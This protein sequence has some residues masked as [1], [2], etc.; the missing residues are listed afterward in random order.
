MLDT[1]NTVV[2]IKKRGLNAAWSIFRAALLIGLGFVILYPLLYMLSMS[3][4]PTVDLY[5]PNVV[6]LPNSLTMVNIT[7]VFEVMEYPK[8][9]GLTIAFN[10]GSSLLSVAVCMIT[11]YGFARFKF[12]GASLLFAFLLMTIIVPIQITGTPLFM[13][14]KALGILDNPLVLYLPALFGQGI[15]SGLFVLIF[16]Q[17]F[18]GMPRELED[19]AAIDGCSAPGIFLR[20]FVPNAGSAMLT[21]F[22]FSLVF[23]WNDYFT[24][25][26][27]FS[28]L[29]TISIALGSLSQEL[30][31]LAGV[32]SFDPYAQLTRMQAGCLLT[33]SPMLVLYIILQRNFTESI[34]RVG[35]VG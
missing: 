12:R 24:T 6:W 3:F 32:S 4:R 35:L 11:G 15:S 22:L 8:T 29:K 19:A 18:K 33:I 34:E 2:W 9:I 26:M 25:G 7:H 20:I 16:R 31:Y 30:T 1:G 14:Y 23:Y 13:Q 28:N 21:V 27:F 5:D 17:F 10:L